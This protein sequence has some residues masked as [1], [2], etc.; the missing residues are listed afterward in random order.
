MVLLSQV[1]IV[2]TNFVVYD[3]R[4]VKIIRSLDKRYS[5]LVLGWNREGRMLNDTE[6]M[7][8]AIAGESLDKPRFILKLLNVRAPFA[9]SS[10]AS[11]IS[12]LLYFPVFWTW[13]LFN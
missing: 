8:I 11:Y 2:R 3:T 7:K 5:T 13:T 12:M 10:L 4:L 6:G 1:A 9:K